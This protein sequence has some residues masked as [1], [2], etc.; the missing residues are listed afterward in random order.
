[1]TTIV[2]RLKETDKKIETLLEETR[3]KT[4]EKNQKDFKKIK[5]GYTQ[6]NQ[7]IIKDLENNEKINKFIDTEQSENIYS[8]FLEQIKHLEISEEEK[9]SYYSESEL[10]Y[11]NARRTFINKD[12]NEY[13][14][15]LVNKSNS[16]NFFDRKKKYAEL[17]E[18][19]IILRKDIERM[20][21]RAQLINPNIS[22]LS[23]EATLRWM[24]EQGGEEELK[25]IQKV[26]SNPPYDSNLIQKL[27]D[28]AESEIG[29]RIK[30]NQKTRLDITRA[31]INTEFKK[32]SA[33]KERFLNLISVTKKLFLDL[34]ELFNVE[35]LLDYLRMP[36]EKEYIDLLSRI[37]RKEI[38]VKINK[39]AIEREK[40][41]LGKSYNVSFKV[42]EP[43]ELASQKDFDR[44]VLEKLLAKFNIKKGLNTEWVVSSSTVKLEAAINTELSLTTNEINQGTVWAAKFPL[45]IPIYGDSTVFPLKITPK[46]VQDASLSIL[47]YAC[48]DLYCQL[49]IPLNVVSP[50]SELLSEV[51]Y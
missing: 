34:G 9:N 12:I 16:I 13:M 45:Y 3:K 21:R 41:I 31:I 32:I 10:Y 23:F 43:E 39:V 1:M 19:W 2:L 15:L 26:K 25:L 4:P 33:I 5:N 8:S 42:F 50:T 18:K 47:I 20:E 24:V 44:E 11:F 6:L 22:Q 17:E 28:L 51:V 38:S 36:R 48:G 46:V 35:K 29:K 7:K 27:F 40:L 37:D 49:E 30:Q 14:N